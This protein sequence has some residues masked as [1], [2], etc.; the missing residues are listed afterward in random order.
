MYSSYN[1]GFKDYPV[2][3]NDYADQNNF[4]LEHA[5]SHSESGH[6]DGYH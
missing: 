1:R 3:N 2:E 6:D 5:P 4:L